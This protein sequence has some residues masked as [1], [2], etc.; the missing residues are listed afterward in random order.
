MS[1]EESTRA[2][3]EAL[4]ALGWSSVRVEG[5]GGGTLAVVLEVEDDETPVM[6]SAPGWYDSESEPWLVRPL[7]QAHP[8][9]DFPHYVSQYA[10]ESWGTL[11]E[12]VSLSARVVAKFGPHDC[13]D[14][15]S[16][17]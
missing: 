12:R 15:P 7:C 2:M 13:P 17:R 3:A 9:Y 10:P 4:R 16:F 1:Y 5:F 6:V 14:C 11:A 8:E